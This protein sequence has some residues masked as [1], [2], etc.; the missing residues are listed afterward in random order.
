MPPRGYRDESK[1][2][3]RSIDYHQKA[4][5]RLTSGDEREYWKPQLAERSEKEAL[6]KAAFG[7]EPDLSHLVEMAILQGLDG[8]TAHAAAELIA[9]RI[10][11]TDPRARHAIKKKLYGK[12]QKARALYRR[13]AVAPEDPSDAAEREIAEA[14]GI[15]P[16]ADAKRQQE[17]L[18]KE[19]VAK[20]WARERKET[21]EWIHQ[22]LEQNELA[23]ALHASGIFKDIYEFARA[24]RALKLFK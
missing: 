19:R 6:Q 11:A 17:A 21:L 8:M 23:R 7:R 10:G 2:L 24:Y 18:R 14:L 20:Y 16:R 5:V 13:L 15:T 22:E 3:Q 9:N 12:F 4:L 1:R